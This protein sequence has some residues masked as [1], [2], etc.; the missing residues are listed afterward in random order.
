ML[1]SLVLG[2]EGLKFEFYFNTYDTSITY[3]QYIKKN[4]GCETGETLMVRQVVRAVLPQ[5]TGNFPL[6]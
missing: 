4:G 3:V 1:H 5:S 6:Q 2:G